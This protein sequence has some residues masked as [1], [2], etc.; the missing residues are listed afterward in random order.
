MDRPRR[1]IFRPAR[2]TKRGR[3]ALE[4]V[5]DRKTREVPAE[6]DDEAEVRVV[7]GVEA[8]VELATEQ[9]EQPDV[10]QAP[11][12]GRRQPLQL[13]ENALSCR[14]GH[15]RCRRTQQR[16]G[17]LVHPK[18]ELVLEAHRPQ[19]AEG[20]VAEDRLGHGS[21]DAGL[22]VGAAVVRVVRL[23]RSDMDGDRVEREVAGREVGVDPLADRCE[24]D[25][26]VDAVGDHPPCSVPLRQRE[27]RAS[28]AAGEA[29]R[30]LARVG[31][32]DVEV[33]N[34]SEEE[35]V[36]DGAPDDPRLLLRQDLAEA[37]IHR[38]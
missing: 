37:L 6:D 13:R 22:E 20:V 12:A 28:E 5:R 2:T 31:T 24:V 7:E 11:K 30:S 10:V 29:V 15:E 33:E 14:L 25:G 32:G 18:P 38:S 26:L 23:A 1:G 3:V 21:D 8:A 9:R 35:L 27:D 16:L 17:S 4:L 34:R 36:A 19:E